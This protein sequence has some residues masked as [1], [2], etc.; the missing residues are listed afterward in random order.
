MSSAPR[1]A[2]PIEPKRIQ[3]FA[4]FFK[5]YMS[6]SSVVTA[7]LPIPVTAMQ[8]IPTYA[9]Q[10]RF[11]STYTSLFCFLLLAFLFYSRHALARAM[12]RKRGSG[13][14]AVAPLLLIAASLTIVFAYH[15]VLDASVRDAQEIWLR[16]G[17]AVYSTQKILADTDPLEI[18]Q[19]TALIG[20]HMAMF[21]TAEAAFILMALREYLQDL[22]GLDEVQLIGVKAPS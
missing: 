10:T 14:I 8:L 12:F 17:A 11:L 3:A 2:A 6:V 13:L 9:A 16:K 21:L 7:S 18:P 19:A 20:L 15:V 5:S 22:L 4:R 1:T